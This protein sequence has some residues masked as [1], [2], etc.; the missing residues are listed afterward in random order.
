MNKDI[1]ENGGD[2][3]NAAKVKFKRS[4]RMSKGMWL[5]LMKRFLRSI[6]TLLIIIIVDF[7]LLRLMPESNIFDNFDKLSEATK[8][9]KL[10]TL[11]L[12]KSVPEQ[13]IMFLK[14]LFKG[15]LGE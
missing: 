3:L 12:D 14:K 1:Q 2:D 9:A 11:G 8:Q 6:L 4:G 5:Y 15:D 7:Y 13:I 10:K